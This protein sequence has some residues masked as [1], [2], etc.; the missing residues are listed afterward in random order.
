MKHLSLLP[1]QM[2]ALA[3]ACIRGLGEFASLQRWRLRDRLVR[4]A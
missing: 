2:A 3:I 1:L 4:R